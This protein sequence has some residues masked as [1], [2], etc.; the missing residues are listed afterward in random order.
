MTYI[1]LK[2]GKIRQVVQK[3]DSQGRLNFELDG[4]AYEVGVSAG[5]LIAVSGYEIADAAWATAGKPVR[6]RVK[7]LNKGSAR[8]NT[9]AIQWE[10]PSEGVTFDFPIG[11]LFGLGPGESGT[12]PVTVTVDGPARAMVKIVAVEGAK[13]MPI[14]VPL[15]PAA[16]PVKDFQIADGLRH[17]RLPARHTAFGNHARRGEWRWLRSARRSFRGVTARWRAVSRR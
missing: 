17:G 3:A 2:D 11:R 5:A 12:L 15:F 9:L 4:D 1:H 10:S 6:L 7:F 14:E 8:S 16:A 13:R